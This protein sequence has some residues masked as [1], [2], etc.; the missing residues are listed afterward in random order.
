MARHTV[1]PHIYIHSGGGCWLSENPDEKCADELYRCSCGESFEISTTKAEHI[2][3]SVPM[4]FVS[5]L[6]GEAAAEEVRKI[7]REAEKL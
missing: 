6:R 7:M 5:K 1:N 4:E 2:S 3:L